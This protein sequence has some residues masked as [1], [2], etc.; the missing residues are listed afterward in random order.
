LADSNVLTETNKVISIR[1]SDLLGRPLD[2]SI[3]LE[4]VTYSSDGKK[5]PAVEFIQAVQ[6]KTDKTLYAID[7]KTKPL[8]KGFFNIVLVPKSTKNDKTLILQPTT[9]E[10]KQIGK[11]GAVSARVGVQDVDQ[12]SRTVWTDLNKGQQLSSKVELEPAQKLIVKVGASD[13]LH[14]VFVVLRNKETKKEVAFIAQPE[15]AGKTDY[16]LE[17]VRIT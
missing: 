13:S 3:Q 14:Q 7:L 9:V 4:S 17:L 16:K 12:Q 8:P 10:V 1:G 11:L 5:V 6:D 15:T 2:I